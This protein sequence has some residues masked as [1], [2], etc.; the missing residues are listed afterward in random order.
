MKVLITGAT[1]LIGS[2]IVTQ[3]IKKGWTV[4]YLTRS[5]EKIED[6]KNYHGFHWDI[7]KGEI[8]AKCFD[9]VDCI[10]NLAGASIAE[11][12]TDSYKETIVDSRVNSLHFLKDALKNSETTIN[13]IISA[14]A[15]GIY[16]DSKTKYFDE[17]NTSVSDSF[18]G[19][20]VE[21]WESALDEFNELGMKTSKVRIGLVLSTEGGALPQMLKPI[22]MYAGAP[23][24]DGK[25]WQS[26]IH[27][28]DLAKLFIFVAEQELAGVYNAVAPNP[29]TNEELTKEVADF[30]G[31]PLFL[32][33]IPEVAM[34]VVLGEMH[35]L[36]FESQR[37]SSEK[38]ESEGFSFKYPNLKPAL[39]D[40]LK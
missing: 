1:G 23:F 24:G 35:I 22:K 12:W 16:P 37:V 2:E 32:P 6:K 18:L 7:H 8:D 31:K 3:C 36:L 33:N 11:R 38:I 14:S 40:L 4:N 10:I 15:I 27:I 17:N 39:K 29:V 28:H 26:W 5:E 34:K 21:K 25:Q 30:L 19:E 20:V 9:G 13:H